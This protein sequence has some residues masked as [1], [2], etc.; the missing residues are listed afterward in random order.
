MIVLSAGRLPSGQSRRSGLGRRGV[1]MQSLGPF[2][3]LRPLDLVCIR[4]LDRHCPGCGELLM[5][6]LASQKLDC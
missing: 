3:R 4:D 6:E 1:L 2:R 5:T